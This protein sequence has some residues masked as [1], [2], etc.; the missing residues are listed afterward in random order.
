ML[1]SNAFGDVEGGSRYCDLSLKLMDLFKA[2]EWLPRVYAA[3]YG[4][5]YVYDRPFA[6]IMDPLLTAYRSGLGTGDFEVR[7]TIAQYITV[8]S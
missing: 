2:R 4:F 1:L 7:L 5:C 8:S 6:D 3:C